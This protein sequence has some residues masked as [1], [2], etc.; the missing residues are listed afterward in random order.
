MSKKQ[1]P[2]TIS[3]LRK[4]KISLPTQNAF[5][6]R[7]EESFQVLSVLFSK[8]ISDQ[9]KGRKA[10]D[11]VSPRALDQLITD[12]IEPLIDECLK[13][14][15]PLMKKLS[16]DLLDRFIAAAAKEL[17]PATY[18]S[19]HLDIE[20]IGFDQGNVA[21]LVKDTPKKFQEIKPGGLENIGKHIAIYM[22]RPAQ[23]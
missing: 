1:K 13:S 16:L 19:V 11:V 5:T 22:S 6:P 12:C 23:R 4:V 14:R 10:T 15:N 20:Y 9:V 18:T 3:E 7:E 8:I 21:S 17:L 2:T